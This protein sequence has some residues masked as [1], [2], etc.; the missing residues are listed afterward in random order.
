MIS[1]EANDY[2]FTLT[3]DQFATIAGLTQRQ[4]GGDYDIIEADTNGIVWLWVHYG[5]RG[6]PLT[7]TRY[8]IETNGGVSLVEDV[9]WDWKGIQHD[10]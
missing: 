10:H 8:W 6:G 9:T 3:G 2:P 1:I 5:Q 7:P 4:P